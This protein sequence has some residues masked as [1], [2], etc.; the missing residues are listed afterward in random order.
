M[1]ITRI[2]PDMISPTVVKT[3]DKAGA[4]S[5]GTEGK[6][7]QLNSSNKIATGY[8]DTGTTNGKVVLADGTHKIATSLIDTGTGENKI[9]QLD[10]DS[11]LP[12]VDGSL[13]TSIIEALPIGMPLQIQTTQITSTVTTALSSSVTKDSETLYENVIAGY[14]TTVTPKR[15]GSKFLVEVSW[16]GGLG[17][18]TPNSSYADN[19]TLGFY[20]TQSIA[21]GSATYLQTGDDGKRNPAISGVHISF[22]GHSAENID[23]YL[24]GSHF[25]YL[26]S[27]SYTAG[28]TVKFQLG[29][30]VHTAS[31]T[32]QTN[33]TV[34][35]TNQGE[36]VRAISL[37][38]VTEV[39]YA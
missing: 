39:R 32:L 3:T 36:T 10:G 1:A 28:Q 4:V 19:A 25:T 6:V 34:D 8:L 13:L 37:M 12:A 33:R 15:T 31:L 18:S 35:D 38:N 20:L 11:K 29:A 7:V 21:G 5:G 2:H 16:N 9:V 24:L 17:N 30:R 23:E 27:P 14:E 22:A 26:A